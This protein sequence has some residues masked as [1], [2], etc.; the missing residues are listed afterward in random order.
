[1]FY[2]AQFNVMAVTIINSS[3]FSMSKVYDKVKL[4]PKDSSRIINFDNW[5]LF[6]K[7][8]LGE[9]FYCVN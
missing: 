8:T 1:M 7:R 2:L 9:V 3:L 6:V 5:S 4:I